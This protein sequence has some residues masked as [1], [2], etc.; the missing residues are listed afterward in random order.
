MLYD[1]LRVMTDFGL[2]VLIWV[3]QLII[4]PGFAFI[5][6][7]EFGAWHKRYMLLITFVVAPLMFLQAGL[8]AFQLY[9]MPGIYT[10]ISILLIFGVWLLT[11]FYAV[12]LHNRLGQDG[13][14]QNVKK[15]V[16]VN[17]YRTALWS[18]L[19]VMSFARILFA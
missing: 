11:F 18:I 19:W 1:I 5:E 15:L 17:W 4:Y 10:M 12:P 14:V 16:R 9:Q 3:V 7:K 2:L 6:F 13:H 8:A